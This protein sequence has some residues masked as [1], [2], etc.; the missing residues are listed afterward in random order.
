M[1]KRLNN[2]GFVIGTFFII[3]SLILLIGGLFSEALDN[4]LDYYTGFS[5]LI[6]GFCMAFFNRK[7]E[8]Q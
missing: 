1:Y 8:E 6:F 4:T 3:V 5:F 7:N 2:L